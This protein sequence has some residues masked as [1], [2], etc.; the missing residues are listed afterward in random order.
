[1]LSQEKMKKEPKIRLIVVDLDG[2]LLTGADQVPEEHVRAVRETREAGVLTVIAT[3][4]LEKESVFAA[5]AVGAKD[6]IITMNGLMIYDYTKQK[7]LTDRHME[8]EAA[9]QVLELLDDAAVF[10]Q[11]YAGND[12][13][14]T[15][16]AIASL[17][18]SGMAPS[19][20]EHYQNAGNVFGRMW[21]FLQSH[22]RAAD[23]LFISIG[24]G[25]KMKEIQA[26][27]DT[28]NGLRT[29]ASGPHFLE[30]LPE[31]TD[32]REAVQLLSQYLHIPLSQTMILGDSDN[33]IGM[34]S[35]A[36]LSVAMGNASQ[37]VKE[38]A[39]VVAPTNLEH[40]VAWA[41]D[42]FVLKKKP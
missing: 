12:T 37:R 4:R 24:D 41:I 7:T 32:K 42:R 29:V 19:Y 2:T 3:G 6:Y 20:L 23:K 25:D 28:I 5:E 39:D 9:R 22:H 13:L 27:I 21:D 10:Y 15:E 1:M 40:G 16:Q 36:G 26:K 34:L 33:D 14:T 35:V 17:P 31:N 30:V 18:F 38:I 8:P 11:L